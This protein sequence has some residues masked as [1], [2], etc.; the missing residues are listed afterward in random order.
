MEFNIEI[1]KV[2]LENLEQFISTARSKVKTILD[3][4]QWNEQKVFE[5]LQSLFF[6]LRI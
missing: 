4:L 5:V 2:Q 1:R 6:F 3:C